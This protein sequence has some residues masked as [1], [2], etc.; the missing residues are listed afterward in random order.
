MAFP[1][2]PLNPIRRVGGQYVK[3]PSSYQWSEQDISQPDAGR[4]EDALM[5]KKMI[6]RAVKLEFSWQNIKLADASQILNIFN[7]EYMSIE[8][9]DVKQGGYVTKTFYVGD[10]TAPAYN[11]KLNVWT[12]SFNAIER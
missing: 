7:S 4:T 8:Y 12:L 6:R 1:Y 10:R 2:D 11:V 3:T 9:L 5:H